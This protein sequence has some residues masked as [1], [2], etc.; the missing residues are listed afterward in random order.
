VPES[1]LKVKITADMRQALRAGETLR[2]SVLRMLLSA[3]EYKEIAKR[4]EIVDKMQ[5]SKSTELG[6]SDFKEVAIQAGLSDVDIT[7]VIAREIKQ[8]KESIEAFNAGNR[9][10]L[11]AKEEAEMAILQGYMP[12]QMGKAEITEL[13]NKAI[14]ETG[15]QG[16][17]DK[18]KVMG[19][20]MPQ[21]RG[22]ADGNEVNAVVND[23][24]GS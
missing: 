2:L 15:A 24:L 10:E 19:K 7:G 20:L 3:M 23:L 12:Q 5:K 8:R 13:V 22:K 9:P 6:D 4:T 17:R 14:A 18:G 21:V 16:P 1:A 11:A